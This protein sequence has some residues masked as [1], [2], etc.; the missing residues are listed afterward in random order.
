[1]L[2]LTAPGNKRVP[3]KETKT[4]SRAAVSKIL[5]PISIR[6]STEV[7]GGVTMKHSTLDIAENVNYYSIVCRVGSSQELTYQMDSMSNIRA[8]YSEID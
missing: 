6:I 1:M 5:D 4:S 8:G 2:F 3:Q 7:K